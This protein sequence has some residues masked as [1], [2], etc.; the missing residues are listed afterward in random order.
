MKFAAI[1]AL[2]LAGYSQS[3]GQSAYVPSADN[4]RN[5]EWFRDAKF[6]MFIHW[7]VYSVLGQGEWVMQ[8]KMMD[9]ET[10]GRVASFFNPTAFDPQAWVSLAKAAGMK[11]ITITSRHHDGFSMFDTKQSDWSIV[12]AT[13]YKKDVL[14]LLAEEC[15]R[16]G[17]KLFFYYSHLDWWNVDYYPRGWTGQYSGRPDSGNWQR[18]LSFVD[19]QLTE[20]LTNYGPVGGIWFD[21]IWDRKEA[22]WELQKTYALIHSL[23]SGALVGNNHHLPPKEG[24]DFQ[25][26]EKDLPGQNLGGFSGSATVSSLPL[27]T[28]ET[29]NNSWGFNITDKKFKTA[30]EL[31][32]MLVRAAGHN[33]NFLLNV[34]P[35]PNG[36]IQ[37]EFVAT[38]K[39]IGGWM[40]KYGETIYGTRGGPVP[41]RSWGVTTQKGEKVF[42]HDLSGETHLLIPNFDKQVRRVSILNDG[43]SLKFEQN[44][45]GIAI[46][47]PEQKIDPTDTIL[48]LSL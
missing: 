39:E 1:I 41:A 24:E 23:Q 17:I 11:Y 48:E 16:E 5:R 47:I 40:S 32:Q 15:Q 35:M 38:L 18:Y 31:I 20:L 19:A 34:G 46:Q 8:Q 28:C 44:D 9:K 36:E 2:A 7:G 43:T 14:K 21:G 12:K 29:M 22:D 10:Y 33:G 6:G 42:A 27:E 3:P 13:P 37:P 25:M 4:L 26:F 45:I 30:R